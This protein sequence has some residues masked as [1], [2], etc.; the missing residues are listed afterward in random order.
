[1]NHKQISFKPEMEE[2]CNVRK[3]NKIEHSTKMVKEKIPRI[4]SEDV[5]KHTVLFGTH[6]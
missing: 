1:M 3:S 4:I 2:A 5:D 6:S